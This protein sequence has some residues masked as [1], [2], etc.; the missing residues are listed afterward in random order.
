M[1]ASLSS[2]MKAEPNLTPLRYYVSVQCGTV[3]T[4]VKR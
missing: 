2:Q 4:G 1:S 3:S